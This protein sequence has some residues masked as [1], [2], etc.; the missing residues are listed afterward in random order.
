M[1]K[2]L[3]IALAV[4]VL[5]AAVAFFVLK[6]GDRLHTKARKQW[7]ENAVLEIARNSGDTNWLA[8]EMASLRNKA[9]QDRADSDSWLS[10]RM[11]LAT[12]S[13]WMVYASKCSKEDHRIHD[14]FVARASDG[15]WYYSTFHFCIGMLV[16]KM[17]PE[18]Q[19]ANLAEFIEGH[20]LREFDGRSDKCLESTWPPKPA[21]AAMARPVPQ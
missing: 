20:Y 15:K 13:D 19:P 16:L 3:A 21:R 18:H 8:Q 1:K 9:A 7:K 10:A 17:E 4:A 2:K 6:A 5:L 12:N 14:I 11:I